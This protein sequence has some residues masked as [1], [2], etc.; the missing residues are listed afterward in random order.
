MSELVVRWMV[1]SQMFPGFSEWGTAGQA[2]SGT[3]KVRCLRFILYA[4]R[5]ARVARKLES[6]TSNGWSVRSCT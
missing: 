4:K 5:C 3:C 6:T 2:N 1:S